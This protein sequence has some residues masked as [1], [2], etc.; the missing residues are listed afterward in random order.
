MRQSECVIVFVYVC[1]CVRENDGVKLCMYMD[2]FYPRLPLL[3]LCALTPG[4]P[5]YVHER[6]CMYVCVHMCVCTRVCVHATSW[7]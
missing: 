3:N 1:V 5:V 4:A 7:N 2:V 6:E